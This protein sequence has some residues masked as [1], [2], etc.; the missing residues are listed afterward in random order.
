V[1]TDSQSICTAWHTVR[2]DAF[3]VADETSARVL[4]DRG[5]PQSKVF[6]P[7][8]PVSLAFENLDSIRACQPARDQPWKILYMVNSGEECA[9]VVCRCLLQIPGA[10]VTVAVGKNEA[11]GHKLKKDAGD[12]PLEI[13]GWAQNMPELMASHH[14]LV[15]KA[16]G[17]TVHECL[18][19][20]TPIVLTRIV[21]GQEE[22][23]ARL[24]IDAGAGFYAPSV[25]TIKETISRL[26]EAGGSGWAQAS[27]SARK[28]G[29]PFAARDSARLILSNLTS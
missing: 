2:T 20:G 24:V 5:I 9:R 7:G 11:L 12:R 21:P 22:G 26:F 25:D 23:N 14:V 27:A 16:G 29:H 3:L 1:V 19:A 18:A 17:A 10:A 8:F 13:V 4:V 15:G 6:S 28:L